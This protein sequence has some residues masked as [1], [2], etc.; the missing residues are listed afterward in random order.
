MLLA[1]AMALSG[2]G[3]AGNSDD[4]PQTG[5]DGELLH[6]VVGYWGGTCESPIFVAYENGLFK[7]AG[8]DVELLKITGD[9][10]ILMANNELDAFELTPDKFKPMEQGLELMIIDSLHK[11][12]IQG[13]TTKE[14][15]I[16]T[17]ADLEGKRVGAAI[18][19]I[20]QIQIA[21]EMVKMGKDPKKVTWL[22]YPNPQ[23]EQAMDQGEIDAFAAYDPFTEIAVQ[24]GKVKFFSNTFDEGLKDYLCCF[25][26]MNKKTL[27][28]NPEIGKRM[29]Q[30]FKK[31][32]EY[33]EAHP[34][35]AAEMVMDKGYVAGDAAL[36][37]KLITDYTWIAGDKKTVDDSFREIWHQLAR[38]GALENAPADLDAYID[39][40][41]PKMV[42]FM[43]EE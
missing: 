8:L 16:K 25:I 14:S 28:A 22:S 1:A 31:A 11:G 21:S 30:A 26:G 4:K 35:D 40:L 32:C 34:E 2:C 18:G 10:A 15:G 39:E 12:C 37:A 38:G 43:G 17:V 19:S 5:T 9:V 36:N 3:T 41:Y 23:L 6:A 29:S 20:P 27:D 24:N 13:A 7:E 42:S 33:L